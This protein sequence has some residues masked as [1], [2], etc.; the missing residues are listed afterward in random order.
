MPS[1]HIPQLEHKELLGS[2]EMERTE[3]RI[4]KKPVLTIKGQQ[5]LIVLLTCGGRLSAGF[6]TSVGTFRFPAL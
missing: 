1:Q 4:N 6:F 5:Q 2:V 3:L